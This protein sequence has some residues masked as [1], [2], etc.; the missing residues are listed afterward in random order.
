MD[1]YTSGAGE[2]PHQKWTT[3]ACNHVTNVFIAVIPLST[4]KVWHSLAADARATLQRLVRAEN[5]IRSSARAHIR[6]Y[7][8]ALRSRRRERD[9]NWIPAQDKSAD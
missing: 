7:K 1:F 9:S 5:L 2:I 3:V 4:Q 6:I 8:T